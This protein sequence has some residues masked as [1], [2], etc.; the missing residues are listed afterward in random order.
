MYVSARGSEYL[1]G[2]HV[3]EGVLP[4]VQSTCQV[5]M[6]VRVCLPGVQSTHQVVMFVRVHCRVFRVPAR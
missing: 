3:C 5:V 2:D 6:F 4:G 1:P